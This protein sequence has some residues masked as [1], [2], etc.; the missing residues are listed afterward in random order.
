MSRSHK[1]VAFDF[2]FVLFSKRCK[3]EGIHSSALKDAVSWTG[4]G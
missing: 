1:K 3:V 2:G 4:R